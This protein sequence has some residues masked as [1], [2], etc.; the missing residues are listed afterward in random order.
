MN[1]HIY[2]KSNDKNVLLYFRPYCNKR[3]YWKVC[4]F[5]TMWCLGGRM[6]D[7][8]FGV[9]KQKD[10]LQL[11]EACCSYCVSTLF[12][13]DQKGWNSQVGRDSTVRDRHFEK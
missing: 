6:R 5:L 3:I 8:I 4:V 12:M 9:E 7:S 10:E 13:Q 11:L 2:C 1:R